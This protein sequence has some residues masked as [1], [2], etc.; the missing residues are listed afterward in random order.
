M[1]VD[2]GHGTLCI[3]AYLSSNQ[4]GRCYYCAHC[5]DEIKIREINTPKVIETQKVKKIEKVEN[6]LSVEGA[7]EN[8]W[9]NK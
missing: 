5:S 1:N 9:K 4:P 6:L 8:L 3:L 2:S 7:R